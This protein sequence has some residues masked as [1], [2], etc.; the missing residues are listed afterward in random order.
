MLPLLAKSIFAM[1]VFA[2][3][4]AASHSVPS[5]ALSLPVM[6]N[7]LHMAADG[8][9][10]CAW[11]SSCQER[12]EQRKSPVTMLQSRCATERSTYLR[13]GQTPQRLGG[14]FVPEIVQNMVQYS[15]RTN[16][17][18]QNAGTRNW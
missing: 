8:C 5:M 3:G 7:S 10:A 16:T 18:H 14:L 15:M 12:Q 4:A 1:L 13:T 6:S 2:C 17:K 11:S 9:T